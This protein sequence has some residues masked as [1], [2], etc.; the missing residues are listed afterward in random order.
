VGLTGHSALLAEVETYYDAVPRSASRVEQIGPFTLFVKLEHG[1]PY[2]ARPTPGATRFEVSD[3][4]RVRARQRELGIPEA[5]E[6][7][8]ETTPA[9]ASAAN[10]GGLH[11]TEHPLLVLPMDGISHNRSLQP[12]RIGSARTPDDVHVSL[13]GPGDD[14]ALLGAIAQVAF[15]H[16]GTA[17]GL[18]G[19]GAAQHSME[20]DPAALAFREERLRTGRTIMAVALFES[21]PVGVG[22]HQPVAAM[23][24][25]VGIAVLPAYRRRGIGAAL[26]TRLVED[27]LDHGVRSAFLSASDETVGRV[28]ERVGFRRIGTACIA[29]PAAPTGSAGLESP[30]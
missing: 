16:A 28:Y 2:Y 24:E 27:A 23:T 3:V 4:Q 25:L 9:L 20:R 26:T 13:V 10:A 19:F 22:S 6:W 14:L 29:E 8:A 15:A 1:W 5:F 7:V 21:Q 17:V 30:G 12:G 11:V 18:A